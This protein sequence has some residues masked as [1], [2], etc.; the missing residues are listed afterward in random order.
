MQST[1]QN[2]ILPYPRITHELKHS[3]SLPQLSEKSSKATLQQSNCKLLKGI[4]SPWSF[5][6]LHKIGEIEYNITKK[7]LISKD[8]LCLKEEKIKVNGDYKT[9]YLFN[10]LLI[11]SS[12]L[13]NFSVKL[14]DIKMKL[15][16]SII[17]FSLSPELLVKDFKT[18]IM[19]KTGIHEN[20][21]KLLY[22]GTLKDEKTLKESNLK[23]NIKVILMASKVE[24]ILSINSQKN[25]QKSDDS[26]KSNSSASEIWSD[27][28]EHKKILDKGRPDDGEEGKLNLRLRIPERGVTN[29]YNSRGVKT[30]LTFKSDLNQL[31]IGTAESTQKI[32]YSSI[33]DVISE[34]IKGN[35][36]YHILALKLGP[37][38]KSNMYFYF[39][40]CQY[41][42][43][44]KDQILGKW[45]IF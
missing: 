15:D 18:L 28:T 17:N 5:R 20:M 14:N 29:L 22:K 24:D 6:N 16:E 42:E 43:S 2:Q 21:Q 40:P 41:I 45:E 3:H 23:D 44:I 33:Q 26:V 27:K 12:N 35:E 8:R 38:A 9:I 4:N 11:V 31:W 30:R 34:P 19:E 13:D 25:L 1:T 36:V 10:D 7:P 39:V 32:T 37:T